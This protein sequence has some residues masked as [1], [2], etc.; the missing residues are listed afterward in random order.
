VEKAAL[1]KK[2]MAAHR[3]SVG[4]AVESDSDAAVNHVGKRNGL[5][6]IGLEPAFLLYATHLRHGL[7][8]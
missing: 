6:G 5:T 4:D 7:T 1:V 3:A 2:A 8:Y